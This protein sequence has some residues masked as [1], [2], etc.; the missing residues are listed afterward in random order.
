MPTAD[1]F[2]TRQGLFQNYQFL[3]R[4]GFRYYA[5]FKTR[6]DRLALDPRR[7][8]RA[9]PLTKSGSTCLAWLMGILVF[10]HAFMIEVPGSWRG[11]VLLV[12]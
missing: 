2:P 12:L 8:R 4:T 11:I 9:G 6:L 7:G 1:Q 5:D 3:E 10:D